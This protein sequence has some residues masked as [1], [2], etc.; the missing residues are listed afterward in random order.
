[1]TKRYKK[2]SDGQWPGYP[3]LRD[4]DIETLTIRQNPYATKALVNNRKGRI[5]VLMDHE[6]YQTFLRIVKERKGDISARSVNEAVA[7]AV[8][9]WMNRK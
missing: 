8:E 6:K 9:E 4:K 2:A 5:V 1:M 7:E 3:H